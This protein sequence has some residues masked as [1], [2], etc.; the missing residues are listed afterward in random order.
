MKHNIISLVNTEKINPKLNLD[1]LNLFNIKRTMYHDQGRN[2]SW[3]IIRK[4]INKFHQYLRGR[5]VIIFIDAKK[6]LLKFQHQF[7]VKTLRERTKNKNIL[8]QTICGQP[9]VKIC[10]SVIVEALPLKSRINEWWLKD[11]HLLFTVLNV[12]VNEIRNRGVSNYLLVK[13]MTN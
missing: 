7:W 11:Q 5:S 10:C 1:K 3:F 6:H 9:V 13:R 2:T 4:S 12:L 8:S